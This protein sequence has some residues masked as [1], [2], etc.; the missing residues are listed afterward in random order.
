MNRTINRF[1]RLRRS[2]SLRAL[3]R[4]TSLA[5]SDLIM[6]LFVREGRNVKRTIASMPGQNQFSVDLLRREVK[7]AV[8]RGVGAVIL[9]GIPNKKDSMGNGASAKDG[10]VQRAIDALKNDHPGLVVIADL[11]L[12]EYTDHGHCGVV[13]RKGGEFCVDNDKTLPILG[14]IAVAQAEAGADIVAPSGMMDGA[15]GAIRDALDAAGKTDTAILSYAAKFSSAF[16]G[17]FRDAAESPP[18]FGD[19]ASYQMD[20]A[21]GDEAMREIA[22]DIDEGADMIMVKP[23]LPYLDIIRRAKDA[24]A[25]PTFAYCV[26]GEYSMVKAAAAKGWIDEKRAVLEILTSIRR[27]GADK[28]LTYWAKDVA[29]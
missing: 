11:C 3:L 15:V 10:I 16:Y 9:F 2:A 21:N 14:K 29:E 28:I 25:H 5:P 17:P 7:S 6:P 27:A 1:R 22:Q 18:Q 24:F 23:A 12:C 4:E 19:R 8:D 26:S 20:S 13:T